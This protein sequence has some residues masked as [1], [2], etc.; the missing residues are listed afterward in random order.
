MPS[1][2]VVVL[3]IGFLAITFA[4]IAGP[5]S[6]E[7]HERPAQ[8]SRRET[9]RAWLR[10][11]RQRPREPLTTR[12]WFPHTGRLFIPAYLSPLLIFGGLRV[13]THRG[14]TFRLG[15]VLAVTGGLCLLALIVAYVRRP[16]RVEEMETIQNSGAPST[17][18]P[19]RP[20]HP[21]NS[22]PDAGP[23]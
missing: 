14:E 1:W 21:S 8:P 22:L 3:G 5:F 20:S 17:V 4:E 16:V 11:W 9:L 23:R 7:E 15:G 19:P 10:G 13:L 6:I 12:E 2:L 18:P